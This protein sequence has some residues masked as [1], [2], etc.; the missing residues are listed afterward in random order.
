MNWT[1]LTLIV[2][3]LSLIAAAVL[4]FAQ[5]KYEENKAEFS[6][7]MYIGEQ[8]GYLFRLATYDKIDYIKPTISDDFSKGTVTFPELARRIR[9]DFREHQNSTEPRILFHFINN[10]QKYCH[11]I[12]QIRHCI[13]K[14][15]T[16]K[17]KENILANGE[18]LSKPELKKLYALLGVIDNFSVI[19]LFHDRFANLKSVQRDFRNDIWIGIKVHT[20]L[21][22][23]QDQLVSDMKEI[24]DNE[25]S[26]TELVGITGAMCNTVSSYYSKPGK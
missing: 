11:H 3:T 15:D 13:T 21:L 10:L 12:Y 18:K 6:F 20:E 22:N 17:L 7:R 25:S 1:L 16:V 2:A 9:G 4:P 19:S 5:K 8:L 14:I 26:L 24:R 23:Q